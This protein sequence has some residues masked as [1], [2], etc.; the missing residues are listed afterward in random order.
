MKRKKLVLFSVLFVLCFSLAS[1]T[2]VTKT[3]TNP[4]GTTTTTTTTE[5]KPEVVEG[6]DKVAEVGEPASKSLAA[7]LLGVYPPASAALGILGILF[8]AWNKRRANTMYGLT[9]TVVSAIDVWKTERPGDWE[10]LE[11]KLTKMIGPK[12][13]NVIRAMRGLPEKVA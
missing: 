2:E 8:G 9:Q 7:L 13:E 11:E 1:C 12:A 6:M 4:D 10:Y 5:L 3:T